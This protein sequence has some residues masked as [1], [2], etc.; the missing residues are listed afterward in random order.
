MVGT[1]IVKLVWACHLTLI[2]QQRLAILQQPVLGSALALSQVLGCLA[3]PWLSCWI[4]F[5]IDLG[6]LRVAAH[7]LGGLRQLIVFGIL[8]MLEL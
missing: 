6:V 8:V 2:R 1:N 3:C 4:R 7:K 5:V